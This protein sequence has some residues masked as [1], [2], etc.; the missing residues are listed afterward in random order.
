[1]TFKQ[2]TDLMLAWG[3]SAEV[4]GEAVGVSANTILRARR[5]SGQIRP[6][7]RG[8][9]AAFRGLVTRRSEVFDIFAS[10][11][12]ETDGDEHRVCPVCGAPAPEPEAVTLGGTAWF[13][14]ENL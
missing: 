3:F 9:Q 1:M 12:T 8:W 7:P 5:S 6:P 11:L 10:D 4:L 13:L 2:A 14:C